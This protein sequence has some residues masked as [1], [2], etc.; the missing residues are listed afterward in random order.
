MCVWV[1]VCHSAHSTCEIRGQFVGWFS[2]STIWLLGSNL[3]HQVWHQVTLSAE[4]SLW[5]IPFLFCTVFYL[6]RQNHALRSRLNLNS[7]PTYLSQP[8]GSW[9]HR[10][11]PPHLAPKVYIFYLS[12]FWIHGSIS[13][14]GEYLCRH[15]YVHVHVCGHS[16][17]LRPQVSAGCL[18]Y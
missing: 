13:G 4:L 16:C 11:A 15:V 1:S 10:C 9:D 8:S 5:P 17:T 7:V 2:P 12:S 14:G 6:L 3:G 18:L